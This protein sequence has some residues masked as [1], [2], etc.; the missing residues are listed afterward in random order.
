MS[1]YPVCPTYFRAWRPSSAANSSCSIRPLLTD[2][3]RK[4]RLSGRDQISTDGKHLIDGIAFGRPRLRPPSQRPPVSIP[5]LKRRRI[6]YNPEEE[7]DDPNDPDDDEDIRPLLRERN[8]A[9][10]FN[11]PVQKEDSSDWRTSL[12][13]YEDQGE[14]DEERDDDFIEDNAE[15]ADE[16]DLMDDESVSSA[17]EELEDELRDL[18]AENEQLGEAVTDAEQEAQPPKATEAPAVTGLPLDQPASL[19]LI[20]VDRITALRAAFPTASVDVCEKTLLD[21]GRKERNAYKKLLQDHQAKMTSRDMFTY[22]KTLRNKGPDVEDEAQSDASDAESIDSLVKHYDQHGFPAGS[23]FAG[24]ASLHMAETLRNSGQPVKL[25]VHVRFDDSQDDGSDDGAP[26]DDELSQEATAE[27][28]AIAGEPDSGSSSSSDSDSGPE[29]HSSKQPEALPTGLLGPVSSESSS[30]SD[31]SSDSGSESESEGDGVRDTNKSVDGDVD[32][33]SDDDDSFHEKSESDD[34]DDPSSDSSSSSSSSSTDSSDSDSD[35]ESDSGAPLPA[36]AKP[37]S[38][39][40]EASGSTASS[41][42]STGPSSTV[43]PGQ[44][45]SKTQ[46]RNARRKAALQHKRLGLENGPAADIVMADQV[47]AEGDALAIKKAELLARLGL[48]DSEPLVCDAGSQADDEGDGNGDRANCPAPKSFSGA[49]PPEASGGHG[50]ASPE[51]HSTTSDYRTELDVGATGQTVV[52]SLGSENPKK[53]AKK[54]KIRQNPVEDSQVVS[55]PGVGGSP[56]EPENTQEQAPPVEENMDAWREK[57]TYRGV[58]CCQENIELSEPPFPFYQ[59]WDPQQ[60]R[61]TRQSKR[62]LRDQP[63]FYEDG[64]QSRKKKKTQK[65][66]GTHSEDASWDESYMSADPYGERDIVLNYDDEME[67]PADDREGDA[68][69]DLPLLPN[70]VS[71]LPALQPGEAKPGM[72]LTWKQFILSKATNWTPQVCSLTG[73]VVDMQDDGFLRLH[74]AKRDRAFEQTEKEYDDEGNR[75]YDKFEFPGMEDELGEDFELGYRILDIKNMMDPRILKQ[76]QQSGSPTAPSPQPD[77]SVV[78]PQMAEP[79]TAGPDNGSN[80]SSDGEQSTT[81][82]HEESAKDVMGQNGPEAD[83]HQSGERVIPEINLES[84]SEPQAAQLHEDVSMTEDRR[85][86]ISQLINDAGFRK[87]VDP[88]IAEDGPV[89]SSSP[90]RQLEETLKEAASASQHQAPPEDL[91]DFPN[92]SQGTSQPSQSLSQVSSKSYMSADSQPIILEPFH[93]FSDAIEAPSDDRVEYPMLDLPPSDIGSTHSGRQPDPLSIELGNTSPERLEGLAD[94]SA[95]SRPSQTP[96]KGGRKALQVSPA[97]SDSSASS[98]PS[99]SEICL[100]ASTQGTQ[101][102]SSQ[103]AIDLAMKARKSDVSHDLEYEEAMRQLDERGESSDSDVR[104]P[105]MRIKRSPDTARRLLE[106]PI[107]KPTVKRAHVKEEP[108]NASVKSAKTVPRGGPFSIPKGSQVVSLISSSPEP[109]MQENY[110]DE[111][112]DDTYREADSLP[113]SESSASGE[114]KSRNRRGGSMPLA[115][116]T[117]SK[118]ANT[119]KRLASTQSKLSRHTVLGSQ[120]HAKKKGVRG[121]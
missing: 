13:R 58:E 42:T 106:K 82:D 39:S 43:K 29:E 118:R 68:E 38:I 116:L 109:E 55:N 12:V 37:T 6:A 84:V 91:S 10:R 120:R 83:R 47:P 35:S 85:Q 48:A 70:D 93:G 81:L 107:G 18:Q 105:K 80:K 49:V 98:F 102:T 16:D 73:V 53:K 50:T 51:H 110:A 94:D 89:P 26:S 33:D 21:C 88:S 25:P 17:D 86:E 95:I 3:R 75:V 61:N 11:V 121:W 78:R 108:T 45:K 7:D 14:E 104:L 57:I 41:S 59:R 101:T 19:T 28:N 111:D 79:N 4:R 96:V 8:S 103:G 15:G 20:D 117:A 99:L 115:A 87:E 97:K 40:K 27:G 24:T 60:Q 66:G 74:L 34:S 62:K 2:D 44:G 1:I 114:K 9:V 112:V 5:P 32:M 65:S 64:S 36:T 46:R 30:D 67:P 54:K 56:S 31:S 52:S 90:S 22:F 77:I 69:D 23:I 71:A 113:P 119:P 76:P 63:E 100:T 72:I 92:P